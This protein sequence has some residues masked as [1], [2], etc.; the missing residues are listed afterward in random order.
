MWVELK[1]GCCGAHL[2]SRAA[3]SSWGVEKAVAAIVKYLRT[4]YS[5]A[6]KSKLPAWPGG[7]RPLAILQDFS[8]GP[9]LPWL[10][11]SLCPMFF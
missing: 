7:Q 4:C 1:G 2:R 8:L 6:A 5:P 10:L 9:W 3:G 11:L